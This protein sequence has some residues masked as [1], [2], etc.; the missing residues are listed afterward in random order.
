MLFMFGP[1]GKARF[2]VVYGSWEWILEVQYRR[3]SANL[4]QGQV[5]TDVENQYRNDHH[6]TEGK[7]DDEQGAYHG[8][9]QQGE[10]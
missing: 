6:Y 1:L 3:V 10:Q 8:Y 4:P 7:Y 9:H 5:Q 2:F